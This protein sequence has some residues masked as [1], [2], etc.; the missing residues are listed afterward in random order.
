MTRGVCAAL[1]VETVM[2][3]FLLTIAADQIAHSHVEK[4]GGVN[5]WGYRGTVLHQKKGNEVRIVVT[6]GDLAFGWGVAASEAMAPSVRELVSRR[7]DRPGQP[8]RRVTGVTAAAQ[9]LAPAA[10]ASWIDRFAYLRPDVICIVV[11]PIGH[12]LVQSAFLPAR[13]SLA[14]A[15]FGYSPILPLVLQEKAT[16]VHSSLLRLAGNTLAA[17]DAAL[18]VRENRDAAAIVPSTDYTS[19][20]DAAVRAGLRSSTSGVVVVLSPSSDNR[21]VKVEMA[22]SFAGERVRLVDLGDDPRMLAAT[23]RLDGFNFSAAGHSVAAEN[24]APAVLELI[25]EVGQRTQ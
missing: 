19:S 11:D 22:S 10:Y 7:V 9:G 13:R 20:I 25:G 17:A 1:A 2:L 15:M 14:F 4:L 8:D 16:L 12:V 3:A 21:R 5:V 6:G 24:V 23:L 18:G